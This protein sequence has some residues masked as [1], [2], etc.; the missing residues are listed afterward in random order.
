MSLKYKPVGQRAAIVFAGPAVNF[1]FAIVVF[2]VLFMSFGQQVLD[3]VVG[4]VVENSAA[5]AAGLRPGDRISAIDGNAI[6]RFDDIQRLVQL[7]YGAP[8]NVTVNRDG[9]ELQLTVTP[10]V[11]A[12][13]D[14]FGNTQKTPL[15]GISSGEGHVA[16]RLGPVDAF[17]AAVTQTYTVVEETGVAVGQM[18]TGRRGTEDIGGVIKIAKYSGQAAKAGF[19]GFVLFVAIL[20]INLG[21]INLVPV[22][23]LDGGHLLF[24][25][26]EA[27]RGR[28][29]SDRVQEWGLR[30]GVALVVTLMI[31][32]TWNDI[33]HL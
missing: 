13:K 29:L 24:Y 6:A 30:I 5:A 12:G 17:V 20:S 8:M 9:S 11:I 2:T 3:P 14:A 16:E 18:I 21:L 33:V 27:V 19:A 4:S 23:L 1:I 7:G 31:F 15:L 32:A 10:R 22:P 25:A 28:P 26:I